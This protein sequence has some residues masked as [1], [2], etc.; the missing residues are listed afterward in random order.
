MEE[1]FGYHLSQAFT[2]LSWNTAWY[3]TA[4]QAGKVELTDS[5]Y[6]CILHVTICNPPSVSVRVG[7]LGFFL[8]ATEK[9]SE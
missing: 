7:F 1:I 8:V 6:H 4:F 5:K 9:N 2:L 3:L